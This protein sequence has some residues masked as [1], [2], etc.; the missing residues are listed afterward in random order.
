[1]FMFFL[2]HVLF[3]EAETTSRSRR[4]CGDS[5]D[6]LLQL[7]KEGLPLV[8]WHNP[9]IECCHHWIERADDIL[10]L[11]GEIHLDFVAVAVLVRFQPNTPD[12]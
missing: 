3:K 4:Y 11:G 8:M 12:G 5:S 10:P 2:Q 1:M 6:E 7:L 9:L